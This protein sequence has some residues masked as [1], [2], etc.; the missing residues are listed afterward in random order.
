MVCRQPLG[1]RFLYGFLP[2]LRQVGRT[3]RTTLRLLRARCRSYSDEYSRNRPWLGQISWLA[4][5]DVRRFALRRVRYDE[6]ALVHKIRQF[7]PNPKETNAKYMLQSLRLVHSRLHR[8]NS[9]Y[10]LLKQFDCELY[11]RIGYYKPVFWLEAGAVVSFGVAW[12]V[13]GESFSFIRD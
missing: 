12:L 5:L 4:A 7:Q 1:H 6:F 11:E 9:M 3:L 8:S 2:R 13:K 10:G